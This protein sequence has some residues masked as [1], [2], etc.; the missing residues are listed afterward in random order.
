M[1]P[2]NLVQHEI[3][4]A[5]GILMSNHTSASHMWDVFLVGG[6]NSSRRIRWWD[7]DLEVINE[8]R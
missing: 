7:Y 1:K 5:I 8:S 6:V 3:T 2:G 4:G